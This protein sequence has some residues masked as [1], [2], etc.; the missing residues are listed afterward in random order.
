MYSI[1]QE[2]FSVNSDAR[3]LTISRAFYFLS[4]IPDENNNDFCLLGVVMI[5]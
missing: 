3:S 1:D 2:E 4:Y 5:K